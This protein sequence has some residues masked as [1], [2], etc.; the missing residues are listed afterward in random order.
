MSHTTAR[1]VD[2][3]VVIELRH[4]IGRGI[5]PSTIRKRRTVQITIDTRTDGVVHRSTAAVEDKAVALA[6][7]LRLLIAVDGIEGHQSRTLGIADI[8][9][10]GE[11]KRKLSVAHAVGTV[12]ERLRT[13]VIDEGRIS[14]L[15]GGIAQSTGDGLLG[16][17][18]G[19]GHHTSE[20]L[21]SRLS[22]SDMSR[23]LHHTACRQSDR[24]SR[25]HVLPT[26]LVD[27]DTHLRGGQRESGIS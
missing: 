18:D 17:A 7:C 16:I 3:T 21:S 8:L 20:T 14:T 15:A 9:G 10:H 27:G 4:E 5:H 11:G 13:V 22:R 2:T 25:S 23:Y 1:G 24:L 19:S 26:D 12:I 6:V